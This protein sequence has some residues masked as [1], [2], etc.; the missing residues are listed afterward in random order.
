MRC[1]VQCKYEA[2]RYTYIL[3]TVTYIVY[4]SFMKREWKIYIY[5]FFTLEILRRAISRK[6]SKT[7]TDQGVCQ[8]NLQA[9]KL[10]TILPHYNAKH[11]YY[12]YVC[13]H[14]Y[15]VFTQIHYYKKQ[16]DFADRPFSLLLVLYKQ[17][18]LYSICIIF[19]RT[20]QNKDSQ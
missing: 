11:M 8:D 12:I 18:F 9:F 13:M 19:L 4:T 3:F 1:I 2:M 16:F 10:P 5:V 20:N 14:V 17:K 15:L 7:L 6:N